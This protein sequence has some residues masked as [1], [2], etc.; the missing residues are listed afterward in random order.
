MNE[1]KKRVEGLAARTEKVK[2]KVREQETREGEWSVRVRRRVRACWGAL[3]VSLVL[4]IV[5]AIVRHWPRAENRTEG[6]DMLFNKSCS[7]LEVDG[8][9]SWRVG[10]GNGVGKVPEE[11]RKDRG[12]DSQERVLRLLD[13]L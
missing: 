4:V 5:G 8:S 1:G 6:V 7:V 2:T 9:T 3:A 12:V 13:E 11:D 10:R